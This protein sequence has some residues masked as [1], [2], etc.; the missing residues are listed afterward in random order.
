MKPFA[1]IFSKL[2][3]ARAGHAE[4][5][6]LRFVGR[7]AGEAVLPERTTAPCWA[8]SCRGVTEWRLTYPLR[9]LYA[10]TGDGCTNTRTILPVAEAPGRHED[11]E[12][13]VPCPSRLAA[14]RGARRERGTLSGGPSRPQPAKGVGHCGRCGRRWRALKGGAQAQACACDPHAPTCLT[15]TRTADR[16]QC[17]RGR[18]ARAE[19][20]IVVVNRHVEAR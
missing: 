16:C 2:S 14:E 15:C 6:S 12:G 8:A 20:E 19:A 1:T 5:A 10:C 18:A 4:L 17:A 9:G 7:R 3:P 13:Y 11:A